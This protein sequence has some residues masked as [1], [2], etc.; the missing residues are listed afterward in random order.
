LAER[1]AELLPVAYFHIVYTLPAPIAVLIDELTHFLEYM[2]RFLR[3]RVRMVGQTALLGET[4]VEVSISDSGTGIPEHKLSEI[5]DTFRRGLSEDR[6]D[7]LIRQAA[8][9]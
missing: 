2:Y 6:R 4:T 8:A 5:F 7:D 9:G 3:S 1:E